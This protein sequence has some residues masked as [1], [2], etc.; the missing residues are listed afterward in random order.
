LHRDRAR[1]NGPGALIDAV[2]HCLVAAHVFGH[3][4]DDADIGL[5]SMQGAL[6]GT[7]EIVFLWKGGRYRQ[8]T[9]EHTSPKHSSCHRLPLLTQWDARP[10]GSLVKTVVRC[11][12][13][14]SSR[15]ISD[16]P[17]FSWVSARTMMCQG[18]VHG[19]WACRAAFCSGT[20][21][22]RWIVMVW[23]SNRRSSMGGEP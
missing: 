7:G 3:F 8:K 16:C 10:S 23:S 2:R 19:V 22:A 15:R 17:S 21:P 14:R 5:R 13:Y 11:G 1:G 20:P 9:R 6:P 12:N 4:D 18:L